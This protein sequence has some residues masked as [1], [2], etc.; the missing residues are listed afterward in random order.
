MPAALHEATQ[1]HGP[2]PLGTNYSA[3][4]FRR[5]LA[6]SFYGR[7][8]FEGIPKDWNLPCIRLAKAANDKAEQVELTVIGSFCSS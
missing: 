5:Y 7:I 4:W 2:K 1:A 8:D 3:F 6:A